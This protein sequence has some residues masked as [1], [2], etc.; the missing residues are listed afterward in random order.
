VD[1]DALK[2]A[3]MVVLN[4][5]GEKV[6]GSLNPS[7]DTATHLALYNQYERIGGVVHTH[8]THAVIWAQAGH[9]LPCFG[10]TH[11][12][13][14][15]GKVPCTAEMTAGEIGGAYEHET[16]MVMIRRFEE[17]GID[18]MQVPAVLVAGHGPF[19]WG[20]T[21]EKAVYHSVVLEECAR[22]GLHTVRLNPEAAGISQALLDKHYL[23]KHGAGAY[24]GQPGC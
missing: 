15:Y 10:T 4:L 1:Y 3:D 5:E 20:A 18:P 6:E 23:R 22:M 21:V 7:S 19:T 24:Y 11:A 9:D 16:G 14:F 13:Y 2:P 17:E 12:D 8:S